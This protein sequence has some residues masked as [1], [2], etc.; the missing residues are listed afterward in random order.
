MRYKSG[1]KKGPSFTEWTPYSLNFNLC[2][3]YISKDSTAKLLMN[4]ECFS[5]S[6]SA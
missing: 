6:A 2:Y 1:N 3:L 4:L 5:T